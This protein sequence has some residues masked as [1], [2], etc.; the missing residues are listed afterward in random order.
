MSTKRRPHD[1]NILQRAARRRPIMTFLVLGI[2]LSYS[3]ATVWG[4]AYHGYL[5]GGDLHDTL[6]VAPDEIT[7]AMLIL[8]LLP[9]AVF[10]T[11]ANDGRAGVRQLFARAFRWRAH[12]GWWALALVGLP[13]LTV[14]FAVALGD[15]PRS[16]DLAPMLVSQAG[17]LFVNF[18]VINLW[19]ETAWTGVM[20]TRLERRYNWFWAAWIVAIPFALVHVPLQFF[21]DEEVTVGI[22]VGAFVTYLLLGLFVRPLMAVFRR[23]TGDCLLLVGLM[24]S[25]FNRTNNDN[26]IA[27]ELVDGEL[28]AVAMLIA[29]VI[30]IVVIAVLARR[31][32]LSKAYAGELEAR[33]AVRA[34]SRRLERTPF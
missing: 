24:H 3:L 14:T 32:R 30:L 13:A 33:A 22:L 21:L 11:H 9:A 5:P 1:G 25:V 6:G 34:G 26:G 2:G 18:I 7:G 20:H 17:L 27:A 16:V 12:P 8:A 23:A 15:E 4:L 28:R 10:V 29:V 19:E 31:P